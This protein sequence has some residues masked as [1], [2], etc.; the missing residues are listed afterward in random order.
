MIEQP[1]SPTHGEVLRAIGKIEGRLD[2]I[3]TAMAQNRTDIADA[4][5]RLAEAEKRIA[6]GIILAVVVSLIM[7]LL[8][9]IAA[10]RLEFGPRH[11]TSPT[12]PIVQ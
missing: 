8:V 10:P 2:A 9:M 3:I 1:D 5:R 6:Q 12:V 4:F 11:D 7:P